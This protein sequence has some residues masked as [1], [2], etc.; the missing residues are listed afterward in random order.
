M[1][2]GNITNV[3]AQLEIHSLEFVGEARSWRAILENSR[4]M[5]LLIG[6]EEKFP[7]FRYVATARI[8][9]Q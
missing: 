5:Q 9:F 7:G 3:L 8:L 2:V 4:V 6:V 1:R